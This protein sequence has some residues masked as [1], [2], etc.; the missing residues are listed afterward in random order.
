MESEGGPNISGQ[1]EQ[2][3]L[4]A[5]K[6]WLLLCTFK[7]QSIFIYITSF[8]QSTPPLKQAVA[9]KND[10]GRNSGHNQAHVGPPDGWVDKGGRE[11]ELGWGK[12]GKGEEE[13]MQTHLL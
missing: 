12:V 3:Q 7:P 8:T 6:L 2:S 1:V 10:M 4:L 13:R 9:G 5:L 11:E